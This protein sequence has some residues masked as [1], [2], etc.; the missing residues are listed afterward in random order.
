VC[1]YVCVCVCEREREYRW[2]IASETLSDNS[3]THQRTRTY[4][5]YS[6]FTPVFVSAATCVCVMLCVC[7]RVCAAVCVCACMQMRMCA[8]TRQRRFSTYTQAF[9]CATKCVYML[10][11]VRTRVCS[12]VCAY[13]CANTCVR[14]RGKTHI[15]SAIRDINVSFF[16][17]F[18]LQ[19]GW[20]R[21]TDD[22][23]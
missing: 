10:L 16:F 19:R 20:Q 22:S 2:I 9:V 23:S 12:R 11:C 5:I 1:V 4:G 7:E 18:L 17:P 8:V 15:Q 14:C 3:D 21:S 13:V 6:T